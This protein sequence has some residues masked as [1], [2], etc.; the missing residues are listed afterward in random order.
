MKAQHSATQAKHRRNAYSTNDNTPP[1]NQ[2]YPDNPVDCCTL[3]ENCCWKCINWW[4]I[5][6]RVQWDFFAL[7][8][9]MYAFDI[10]HQGFICKLVHFF[11]IPINV[12]L[13]MM[14]LA[15]FKLGL[16]ESVT[17]AS[18]FVFDINASLILMLI[19]VLLYTTM[20]LIRKCAVWGLATSLFVFLLWGAGNCMYTKFSYETKECYD[21]NSSELDTGPKWYN[22]VLTPYNPIMWSYII[23]F[24]QA[25]SHM[26]VP[27]LPPF[28]TGVTHWEAV[29]VFLCRQKGAKACCWKVLA[30]ACFPFTSVA[31]AWFSW[32][33]LIGTEMFYIM[34][35]IGYKHS[36]FKKYKLITQKAELSGDPNCSR[37]PDSYQDM[38]EASEISQYSKHHN[39]A[40]LESQGL[41]EKGK[42]YTPKQVFKELATLHIYQH[43]FHTRQKHALDSDSS[44]AHFMHYKMLSDNE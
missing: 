38:T 26:L 14:F 21:H 30:L 37:F 39:K 8:Y 4:L 34:A 42:Q 40:K 19:L 12:A 25:S 22:P 28:I 32:P 10:C 11:A 18:E 33:H 1:K 24:M 13:S 3:P 7:L 9:Q 2:D 16:D 27:Q 44:D 6:P 43:Y 31:V 15:Q 23:S 41:L 29:S 36:Y 20:G 17:Y 35:G 5:V